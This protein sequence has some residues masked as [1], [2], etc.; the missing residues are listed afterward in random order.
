VRLLS[1]LD[2]DDLRVVVADLVGELGVDVHHLG[3]EF[4][5][6]PGRPLASRPPVRG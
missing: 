3:G 1:G 4:A 6:G 5:D 2:V